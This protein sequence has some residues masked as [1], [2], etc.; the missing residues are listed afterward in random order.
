[1]V[2]TAFA[3]TFGALMLGL[4]IA[5][6]LVALLL[7]G[8]GRDLDRRSEATGPGR[9]T[10]RPTCRMSVQ[11]RSSGVLL[12]PTSLPGSFGVGDSGLSAF[13]FID[14]LCRR[15]PAPVADDAA[16]DAPHGD[17]PYPCLSALVGNCW[18]SPND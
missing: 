12:H 10:P 17:S 6:G 3:I 8:I 5:F 7:H 13:A 16:R 9:G 2:L 1:M 4:A 18:I 15:G 11:Q 14:L